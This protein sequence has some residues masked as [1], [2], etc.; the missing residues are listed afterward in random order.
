[1]MAVSKIKAAGGLPAK[2]KELLVPG[3]IRAGVHIQGGGVDVTGAYGPVFCHYETNLHKGPAYGRNDVSYND[4]RIVSIE[5]SVVTLTPGKYKI[6]VNGKQDGVDPVTYARL[7]I[8][9]VLKFTTNT[10]T[11]KIL[12]VESKNNIVIRRE[13]SM[14]YYSSELLYLV[15]AEK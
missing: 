3:N 11:Q 8:D 15:V 14:A 5:A 1:M 9:E 6:Y 12:D 7:Y 13:S 4:S 2:V 10:D